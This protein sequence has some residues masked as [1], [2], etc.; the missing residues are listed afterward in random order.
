MTNGKEKDTLNL[1]ESQESEEKGSDKSPFYYLRLL[2]VDVFQ[3]PFLKNIS[4]VAI[5]PMVSQLLSILLSPIITRL[6]S[7]ESY[8]ALGAFLSVLSVLVPISSLSYQ[9]AIVLPRKDRDG[10]R[11]LRF[12]IIFSALV[13]C[14]VFF[15]IALF[16]N[17]I[18]SLLKL[19]GFEKDLFLLPLALL[20]STAVIVFD[21]WMIRKK[22]FKASSGI[23]ISQSLL[24][25]G[26]L[27]GLGYF[28]PRLA[29][30]IGVNV[31]ARGFHALSAFIFSLRTIPDQKTKGKGRSIEVESTLKTLLHHYRDFP[32]YRTPQILISTLAY[33][34]PFLLMTAFSGT[35]DTGFY[36]LAR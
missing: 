5:G 1:P 22:Q 17:P 20:F 29:S 10:W 9:Y 34:L 32:Y 16:K 14:L 33:N 21:Q 36:L 25:N 28:V 27:I 31:F 12:I 3:H 4:I 19:E 23:V 2:I 8:G 7:P 6:Y 15:L 13:S 26:G 24:S 11:I 18:A 35:A 30:L